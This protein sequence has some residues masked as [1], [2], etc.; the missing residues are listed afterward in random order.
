MSGERSPVDDG[1]TELERAQ[2]IDRATKT[3]P[4]QRLRWLEEAIVFARATGA[5]SQ[6]FAADRSL[7]DQFAA[8]EGTPEERARPAD[9]GD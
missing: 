8:N 1:W 4:A 6:T 2:L 9:D 5:I 3:T 7:S